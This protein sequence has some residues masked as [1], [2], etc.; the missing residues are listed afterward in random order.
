MT[1]WPILDGVFEL[2]DLPV[3]R[4]GVIRD[5]RLAWQA[6]GTLNTARDNVI[7]Y[8]CSYGAQHDDLTWLIGPDGVLDPTRWFVVVPDMFSNGLSSSAADDPEFPAVV[9]ARDNVLAQRRLLTERFGVDRIAAVY[10]FSMGA[11][12][13]YHWAAA[14]PDAVERAI[15]VCGS[16]RTA[17]HNK[18]FLSGLLRLLEAAPEHLGKGRFSAEPLAALRAFA[19]VYAGWGLSQDFYREELF[20]TALGFPDLDSFLRT[21][22]EESFGRRRAANLYAQ[23]MTWHDADISANDTYGG[24][25]TAALKAIR[26]RVLLV[27]GETDLYF[28][29]ADNA[30]ELPHLAKAE[31][32]SIPSV[33]GHRAGSPQGIPADFAFLRRVTRDWLDT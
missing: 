26:A 20:R 27:P 10:G 29:V 16:A 4:G 15:V 31:L 3:E 1:E 11:I 5:A 24:D 25:L 6:H 19:H 22:W 17:T 9:T 33:W 12:Q 28:R 32:R 23:A 7:V 21:D 2:G 14:F 8:P 18:V 13:A 30:A